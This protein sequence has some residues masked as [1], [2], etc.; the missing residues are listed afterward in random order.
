M[1]LKEIAQKV[2]DTMD[3]R[4]KSFEPN[5]AV[6]G[7]YKKYLIDAFIEVFGPS[8]FQYEPYYYA[9]KYSWNDMELW[10]NRILKE[11]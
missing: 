9:I 7:Y 3:V 1:T 10:A 6:G 11:G 2:L 5:S 4:E 8:H